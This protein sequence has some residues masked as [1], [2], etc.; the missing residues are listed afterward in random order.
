MKT[1][2]HALSLSEKKKHSLKISVPEDELS[3]QH[4]KLATVNGECV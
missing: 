1:N 3:I 2:F 4:C